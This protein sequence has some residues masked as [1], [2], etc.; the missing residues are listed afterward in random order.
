[1]DALE[2]YFA[3]TG[4]NM[5]KLAGRMGRAPS[6]LTRAIKGERGKILDLAREV[7][8]FTEGRV[9]AAEFL[10]ICVA[11]EPAPQRAAG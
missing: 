3:E 6:T 10:A 2:R 5:T 8:R 1:M 11:S 9:K 4:E 7:E